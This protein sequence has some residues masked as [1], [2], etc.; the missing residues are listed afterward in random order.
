MSWIAAALLLASVPVGSSDVGADAT[1]RA[2]AQ[3]LGAYEAEF[4]AETAL[5]VGGAQFQ[6]HGTQGVLRV[7]VLVASA[8]SMETTD[9]RDRTRSRLLLE[10]LNES[11]KVY[12]TAGGFFVWDRIHEAFYLCRDFRLTNREPDFQDE[13]DELLDAADMWRAQWFGE[14]SIRLQAAR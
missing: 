4:D 1:L 5:D 2:I 12:N 10:A 3:D 7:R 9:E 6:L 8:P 14:V 13:I 11:K